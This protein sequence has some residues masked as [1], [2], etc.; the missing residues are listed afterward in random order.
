MR[1]RYHYVYRSYEPL[2]RG[3]IG[4]RSC[5]CPINEDEY[6]GSYTDPTFFPTQKE[7][8]AVC[9]TRKEAL[10]TEM[11]F[12]EMYD[13]ARNPKF[14]NRAKQTS[15]GFSREGVC[16][17]EETLQKMRESQSKV[18]RPRQGRPRSE[19][20]KRKIQKSLLEYWKTTETGRISS[21][22]GGRCS[23]GRKPKPIELYNLEGNYSL[24]FE[25]AVKAGEALN[26]NPSYLTKMARGE[27]ESYKGW[28]SRYV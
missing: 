28:M 24:L 7:I 25:S 5:N 14:A 3:Y 10:R 2:G 27:W 19:E 17:S 26:L 11:F 21:S 20:V 9:E 1:F 22:L 6:M 8:L 15:T 12:H 13:V 18:C 23:K 4:C 16:H